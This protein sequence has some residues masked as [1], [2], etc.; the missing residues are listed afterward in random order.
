MYIYAYPLCLPPLPTP[1]PT[2]FVPLCTPLYPVVP[3]CHTPFASQVGARATRPASALPASSSS[4]MQQRTADIHRSPQLALRPL[5]IGI[6][7]SW[8]VAAAAEVGAQAAWLVEV[9]TLEGLRLS[10]RGRRLSWY[11]TEM[12][13]A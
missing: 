2:P 5:S 6:R 7:S 8:E 4:K 9:S 13:A 11:T 1:L 3:R 12:A 10:Y